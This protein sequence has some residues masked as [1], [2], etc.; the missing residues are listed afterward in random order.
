MHGAKSLRCARKIQNCGRLLLLH[1][2]ALHQRIFPGQSEIPNR[3][4]HGLLF[5]TKLSSP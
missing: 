2:L 5:D 3:A 1:S 4:I